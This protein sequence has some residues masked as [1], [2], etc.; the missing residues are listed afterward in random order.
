MLAVILFRHVS[1][2]NAFEARQSRPVK[3][4]GVTF[5]ASSIPQFLLDSPEGSGEAW[6]GAGGSRL[7]H[8]RVKTSQN[9]SAAPASFSCRSNLLLEREM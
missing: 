9:L 5:T 7:S 3:K 2:F 8:N 4:L 6:E 1:S